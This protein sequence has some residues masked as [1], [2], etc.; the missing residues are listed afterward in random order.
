MLPRWQEA[1]GANPMEEAGL[2]DKNLVNAWTR[3]ALVW[4]AFFP[5]VWVL[6]SSTQF[7]N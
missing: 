4:L 1:D 5:L 6:T 2:V 7:H 3:W